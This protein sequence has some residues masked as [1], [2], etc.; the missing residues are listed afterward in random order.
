MVLGTL[1]SDFGPT[2]ASLRQGKMTQGELAKAQGVDGSTISRYER[3]ELIPSLADAQKLLSSIGAAEAHDYAEYLGQHWRFLPRPAYRHPDRLILWSC[4]STLRALDQVRRSTHSESVRARADLLETGL[5]READYLQSVSHDIAFFGQ[6]AV[7][8]TTALC[9]A[10]ALMLPGIPGERRIKRTILEVGSGN[11]TICEVVVRHDPTRYG[12][13]VAPH[14]ED[15]ITLCINDLCAGVIAAKEGDAALD[16]ERRGLPKEVDRA[17]RHMGNLAKKQERGPDG[18]RVTV[19]PIHALAEGRSLSTLASE[20]FNRLKLSQRNQSELWYHPDSGMEPRAWLRKTFADVNNGHNASVGLPRQIAVIAPLH[21]RATKPYD[22]RMIDTRGIDEPLADRPDLRTYLEDGRTIPVLC[23]PF[24]GPL[25]RSVEQLLQGSDDTGAG[26]GVAMR[27]MVLLLAKNE[28]ALQVEHA[29]TVEDGYETRNERARDDLR[30]IGRDGGH[31]RPE[32]VS[33]NSDSD[34]PA[35]L[36]EAV[37]GRVEAARSA[38]RKRIEEIGAAVTVLAQEAIEV[39]V[40]K[41]YAHVHDRLRVV[42]VAKLAPSGSRPFE[43]LISAI[44]TL[45]PRT[46]WAS[47]VRHG[48]WVYLDVYHYLGVGLAAEA[49]KRSRPQVNELE[50]AL[51]RMLA[52]DDFAP[53]HE[54]LK[55]A[56]RSVGDWHHEFVQSAARLGK[57]AFRPALKEATQLWSTC[58]DQYGTGRGFREPVAGYLQQWFNDARQA[59]V[60]EMVEAGLADQWSTIFVT[61]VQ[62][63]VTSVRPLTEPPMK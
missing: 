57:D 20:V 26:T 44:R 49:E 21:A 27:S 55:E 5:K 45:H 60:F 54:F 48:S 2:L 52:S 6:I 24:A 14:S 11:V 18:K 7:G 35:N 37:I 19:D 38:R 43:R 9:T 56:I 16:G 41:V 42:N 59:D 36:V 53:V 58:A 10:A 28:E 47:V 15:E 39:G 4:E 61:N 3:G 34:D 40:A 50:L 51:H 22:L 13:I 29:E 33:F 32:V 62:K 25:D 63:L 30:R 12:L 23:S 8:K 1:P 31:Q 17:L 46:V